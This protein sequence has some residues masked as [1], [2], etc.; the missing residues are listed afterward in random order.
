[1]S[2]FRTTLLAGG[3]CLALGACAMTPAEPTLYDRLGG[4]PAITQVVDDFIANVAKDKVINRR[5]KGADI[6]ALKAKLVDQLCEAAGGPCKYT[7]QDMRTAHAGM[8]IT[9]REFNAMGRDMLR[10]LQKNKVPARE[11]NE[12]MQALGG[13]KKDIVGL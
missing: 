11:T 3:F 2:M 12:V 8:A 1:M 5:F 6:P 4:R 10:A 7:G 9:D 13:M